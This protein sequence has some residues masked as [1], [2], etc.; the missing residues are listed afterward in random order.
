MPKTLTRKDEAHYTIYRRLCIEGFVHDKA[1]RIATGI[2]AD[3][4]AVGLT[5]RKASG[6]ASIGAVDGN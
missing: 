6:Q 1:Y 2:L 3:L 4:E 5:V